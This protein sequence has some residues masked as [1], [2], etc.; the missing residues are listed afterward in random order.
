M[1][2]NK[3]KDSKLRVRDLQVRGQNPR[4]S[5]HHDAQ[6]INEFKKGTV[7]VGMALIAHVDYVGPS[8]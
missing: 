1:T 6:S 5:L 4:L 3:R 8:Y 7:K 2:P